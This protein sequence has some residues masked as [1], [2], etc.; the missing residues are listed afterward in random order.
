MLDATR[1]RTPCLFDKIVSADEAATLITDGMNVGV[2]GFT[3]SGY[4]KKTTLALAKAIKAGK[5][6]RINIWSGASVGPEIEETLAEVGG[7]S[8]RMPYYAASNK[9]L[10][11]QINTGSVTYIDQHLSHFA[12][13]IDY[14]FYGDVDVAIVEAAAIN[15]DGSI[16]LGSGVGNTPMLVKHAKKIIVEVNTSIPLTLEGMHDIYIC[17][18]PPERTEIPIYHVGDRIGSPYVSCGLDRITCIVESDIVDHVRNLSAPD[19]TSKKIAA[20]LVDF[21]EHEQRHGRLPQQML[22]LQSGVGSIANAVLMGL[23]ESKFENLTM[24]SEILQ[25][26]VFKLIKC[27]KVTQASGCA[28]TPSPTV[29]EMYKEDPEL[30]RNRIVLRPLD[31]SNNPEVIRRLGVISMNTP[32]E[33]DIYGQANSTHVMGNRMMNGIGGSGDYM[34]NGYLTIFSTPSTAKGG[35]ISS[36]VPMVSHA[37]H[38]EHDTMVFITEQGVADIRGLSP[39]KGEMAAHAYEYQTDIEKGKRTVI[40]VN[41]FADNKAVKTND[42]ITA[43]LSV[44]ERQIARVNEMKAHRDQHAVD[45]SLKALKEAAN[46]EANLMPYL[47]DAVKT[48]ATLGEI[49]GVLREVF[50]EYQQG[51]NLF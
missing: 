44:A 43:D 41:K 37:D 40:G 1:L 27:G 23:A 48:Y 5:K 24:Y 28:F 3:P 26:S 8:G 42:V 34:R 36:V 32:L 25:D 6:C 7:I 17:S 31:I 29:W 13:Q 30:Y 18:K 39:R 21:L 15:A 46:G 35:N 14:G 4:P 10:S 20:N 19:D 16:V 9:T 45:A 33:F 11:R 22:P 50:G 49:C 12:Q 47:I 38:T 51:G 2:S